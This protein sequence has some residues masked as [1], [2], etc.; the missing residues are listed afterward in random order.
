M[1]SRPDFRLLTVWTNRMGRNRPSTENQCTQ[2]TWGWREGRITLTQKNG[3]DSLEG[4]PGRQS[5]ARVWRQSW[6]QGSSMAGLVPGNCRVSPMG[7]GEADVESE[8][9]RHEVRYKVTSSC[10]VVTPYLLDRQCNPRVHSQGPQLK[11]PFSE[12]VTV[13]LSW[14]PTP[15]DFRKYGDLELSTSKPALEESCQPVKL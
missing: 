2:H 7:C 9:R 6:L 1:Q 11:E 14:I 13:L 4:I 10:V 5:G 12:L 8:G 15:C 3:L